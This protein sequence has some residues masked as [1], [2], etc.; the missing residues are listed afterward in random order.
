MLGNIRKYPAY[1]VLPESCNCT[2]I[3]VGTWKLHISLFL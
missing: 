3:Y 2:N 1:H